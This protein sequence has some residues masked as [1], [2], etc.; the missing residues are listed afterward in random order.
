MCV[1][2]ET[3][4]AEAAAALPSSHW[5]NT[6]PGN[7]DYS[8]PLTRPESWMQ[9]EEEVVQLVLFTHTHT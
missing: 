1:S 5:I 6:D 4:G 7:R 2:K 8:R 3:A 9:G